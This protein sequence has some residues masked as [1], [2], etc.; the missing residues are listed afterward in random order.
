MHPWR[1]LDLVQTPPLEKG[2][3]VKSGQADCRSLLVTA[4]LSQPDF[5]TLVLNDHG[6]IGGGRVAVGAG[7][8]GGGIV[9]ADPP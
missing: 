1:S 6:A 2:N 5:R 7:G 3:R 9:R 8:N 4:C